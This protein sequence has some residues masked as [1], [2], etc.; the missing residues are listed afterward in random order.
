MSEWNEEE[1]KVFLY[2]HGENSVQRLASSKD[3]IH[4]DYEREVLTRAAA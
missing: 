4:F 1:K 2:F 3:G